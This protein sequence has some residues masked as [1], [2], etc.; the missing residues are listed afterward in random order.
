MKN[1]IIGL[2]I[3]AF[4]IS[5]MAADNFDGYN[6]RFKL[7]RDDSQNITYVKMNMLNQRISFM[8][9]LLQI[10]DDI[11]KEIQR[12]QSESF[13]SELDMMLE[14]LKA[15]SDKSEQLDETVWALR[16][17]IKNLKDVDIDHF[18]KAAQTKNVLSFFQ[19]ELQKAFDKYS[20][21]VIASTEDPRYFYKRNVTYEI[22]K[23]ALDFAKKQFSDIPLLNLASMVIVKVHDLVLEQRLFHQNMLLHY[24]QNA[25]VEDLGL[26]V[27]EADRIFSSIYESRIAV[28]NYRES[29]E[30]AS[31]WTR[32]GLNKFYETLRTANN[33]VRREMSTL[34]EVNRLNFA[35]VQVKEDGQKLIKNIVHN[36]HSFSQDMSI[37]YY[38]EQP[39]KV[40]RFRSLLNLGQVGLGFITLPGWLKSQ[41]NSFVDSY[42]VEQKRLEGALIGHF[43]MSGNMVMARQIKEQ[44][45]NPYIIFN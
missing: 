16:G 38:V 14:E 12:M 44:L 3:L 29:N 39:D 13:N 30:A 41:V 7:V 26:T 35:F 37:A 34:K 27:D 9:Y 25:K 6:K 2:Y 33:R 28:I 23:R 20:L 15:N 19:T 40:R 18:F 31:N 10:R 24:L 22:V 11:K 4:S 43:E 17:S 42:Y 8:P 21:A 5:A 36:K 45:I 32:Y 1:A